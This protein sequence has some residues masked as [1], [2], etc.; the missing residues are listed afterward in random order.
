MDLK[1]LQTGYINLLKDRETQIITEDDYFKNIVASKNFKV[2]NDIV[3]Y[4]RLQG[5]SDFCTLTSGLLKKLCLFEDKVKLFYRE[6]NISGYLEELGKSFLAYTS[7]DKN[8]LIAFVS[9]FELALIKVKLGCGDEFLIETNFNPAGVFN[10]IFSDSDKLPEE[11][12]VKYIVNV[13]SKIENN[14]SVICP[15]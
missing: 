8:N 15:D 5:I 4:W 9:E 14:F 13:S 10:F 2:L 6:T 1:T 12:S 11:E 7:D 3:L